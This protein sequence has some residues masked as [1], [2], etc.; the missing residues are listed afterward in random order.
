MFAATRRPLAF[1]LKP[2]APNRA[3]A[4]QPAGGPL[5]S[6]VAAAARAGP[7]LGAN[8]KSAGAP[9]SGAQR[10]GSGQ[11]NV[12]PGQE[13][14]GTPP[15]PVAATQGAG[16]AAGVQKPLTWWHFQGQLAGST[17]QSALAKGDKVTAEDSEAPANVAAAGED[18]VEAWQTGFMSCFKFEP[19]K[20]APGVPLTNS[21]KRR[22]KELDAPKEG[23]A[24]LESDSGKADLSAFVYHHV[25]EEFFL[26][27]DGCKTE[28]FFWL[29]DKDRDYLIDADTEYDPWWIEVGQ[30]AV[31]KKAVTARASMMTRV[32]EC[33]WR[34][35]SASNC[36]M[37][38]ALH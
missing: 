37:L 3:P 9:R 1:P 28:L 29:T 21:R 6:A 13:G 22:S 7:A 20:Y 15:A 32:K 33:I 38:T 5:P 34:E 31:I 2:M 12:P 18:A 19:N 35:Y 14:A 16:N 25:R 4:S 8:N 27:K 23:R 10:A 24:A 30:R 26:T 11:E 36:A 17:A